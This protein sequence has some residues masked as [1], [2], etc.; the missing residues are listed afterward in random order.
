MDISERAKELYEAY[1]ASVGWKAFNGDRLKFY[2][3]VPWRIK[4][5]WEAVAKVTGDWEE[6]AYQ[7]G[8]DAGYDEGRLVGGK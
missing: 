2:A 8:Y 7:A 1:A 5:A 6:D 4:D 3:E